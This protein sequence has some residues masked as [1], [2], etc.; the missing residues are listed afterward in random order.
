MEAVEREYRIY[1]R[2]VHVQ[3]QNAGNYYLIIVILYLSQASGSSV[4]Y[5]PTQ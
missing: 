2:L 1:D 5:F 4:V 3:D